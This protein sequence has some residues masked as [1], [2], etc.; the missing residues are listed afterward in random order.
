MRKDANV[1]SKS[2]QKRMQ[3][4]V[5]QHMMEIVEIVERHVFHQPPWWTVFS[6]V[7]PWKKQP[8]VET[9]DLAWW[10]CGDWNSS[11]HSKHMLTSVT[12]LMN[13]W[14]GNGARKSDAKIMEDGAN[15]ETKG[16][17]KLKTMY[18]KCMQTTMPKIETTKRAISL[19]YWGNC[20]G[21]F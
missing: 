17:S 7:K 5:A 9:W 12:Q 15:M 6:G 14:C 19:R 11:K 20:G 1:E 10:V 8:A 2:M 16:E 4:H 13:N 21:P 18:V 3:K